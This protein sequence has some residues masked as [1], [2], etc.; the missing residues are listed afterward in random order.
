MRGA[1]RVGVC[2]ARAGRLQGK[3]K[4]CGCRVALEVLPMDHRVLLRQN[5]T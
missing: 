1:S 4:G 3:V 5:L 2:A